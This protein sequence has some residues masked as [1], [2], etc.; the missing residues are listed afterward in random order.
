MRPAPFP[1][2]H[3]NVFTRLF[4]SKI[5]GVGV[6]AITNIDKGTRL[7]LGSDEETLRTASMEKVKELPKGPRQ[8]YEDFGIPKF[9]N[10]RYAQWLVPRNFNSMSMAW[11]LNHS[12][13]PN[14]KWDKEYNFFTT[15][16]IKEGEELTIDYRNYDA[17]LSLLLRE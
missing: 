17:P 13:K 12:E 14:V 16:K 3:I 5:H 11:Y 10:G 4:S 8:L 15:R 6:M 7:F 9:V 2:S 1:L